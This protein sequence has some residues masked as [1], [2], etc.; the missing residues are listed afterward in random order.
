MITHC[1][2]LVKVADTRA[3]GTALLVW[4]GKLNISLERSSYEFQKYPV[5]TNIRCQ[6]EHFLQQ[7]IVFM[8]HFKCCKVTYFIL[9]T[10]KPCV[11]LSGSVEGSEITF[12]LHI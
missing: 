1:C 10:K 11:Q 7:L 12:D 3:F 2:L 5:V 4:P 9:L 8:E 6:T